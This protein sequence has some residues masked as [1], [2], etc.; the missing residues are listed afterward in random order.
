MVWRG[1]M[2]LFVMTAAACNDHPM[3]KSVHGHT[4]T[5]HPAPQVKASSVVTERAVKIDVNDE[6]KIQAA[7]GTELGELRVNAWNHQRRPRHHFT[8]SERP[9]EQDDSRAWPGVSV[10]AATLG[11]THALLIPE[12]PN[13]KPS[14]FPPRYVLYYV[15]PARWDELPAELRPIARAPT[16]D[17]AR[18]RYM[19]PVV[20]LKE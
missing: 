2:L 17:E 19:P 16:A 5:F 12:L 8:S 4:T 9:A 20:T 11:A 6:A 7:G 15:D 13:G 18:V 1:A 10:D 14:Y 3:I